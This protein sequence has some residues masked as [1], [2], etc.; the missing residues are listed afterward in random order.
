[1]RFAVT[2]EQL[3]SGASYIDAG[4]PGDATLPPASMSSAAASTPV[5]GAWSSFFAAAVGA[6]ITLDT[7]SADLAN[8]MRTA[9]S[10]YTQTEA[11]NTG[12]LSGGR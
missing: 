7:V 4:G 6:A 9:A 12:N 2:P 3:V 10:N 5:D 11:R 1:M 8:G